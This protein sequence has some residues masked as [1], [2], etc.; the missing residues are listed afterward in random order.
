L[1]SILFGA[2]L[3]APGDV[4]TSLSCG[5]T[6]VC[7]S[8]S[9]L[10][11]DTVIWQVRMPRIVLAGLV[12]LLLSISGVIMQGVLR[13]PLADPYILGVSAGAGVGAMIAQLLGIGFI[14]FGISAVPFF[15]FVGALVA[16]MLVYGLA[17][18][19]G[20]TSTEAL[21][22]AGVA[23]SAFCAG[24]ISLLIILSGDLQS[25]YFWLLGSLNGA[26]WNQVIA[27]LPYAVVGL[28]V[29]YYYSKDLNALLLGEEVAQTLGVEVEKV[30]M[31]LL[32]VASLMTAAAVSVAGLV[33]FVGLIIPHFVRLII[34]PH[35]RMLIPLSAAAGMFLVILADIPAR[36]IIAPNELPLGVV[37]AFIGAPF[38]LY[39]LQKRSHY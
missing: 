28:G 15:A 6:N 23:V 14:V 26:N 33:G 30:R 25:I 34:G 12:G 4:W 37:M 22:L 31:L 1:L 7:N 18:S 3:L 8:S 32:A 27:I 35:H 19:R 10:F 38:F 11:V 5:F 24:I 2:V 36:S 39:V 16:V 17:A 9:T 29:S 13:N 20:R 21:L